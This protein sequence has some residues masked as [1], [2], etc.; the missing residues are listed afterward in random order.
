MTFALEAYAYYQFVYLALR[1]I[2]LLQNVTSILGHVLSHYI[3]YAWHGTE[4]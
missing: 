2:Y 3:S 1:I 4:E